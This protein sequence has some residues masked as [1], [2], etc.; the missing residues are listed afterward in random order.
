MP[1]SLH[2]RAIYYNQQGDQTLATFTL[3]DDFSDDEAAPLASPRASTLI[4]GDAANALTITDDYLSSAGGAA[5]N[6][7]HVYFPLQANVAGTALFARLGALRG[8]ISIG[9]YVGWIDTIA[10]SLGTSTARALY[11]FRFAEMR[12]TGTAENFTNRTLGITSVASY[13]NPYYADLMIVLRGTGAYWFWRR[14]ATW[15]L[16]HVNETLATANL[17]PRYSLRG[18]GVTTLDK[19]G[20]LDAATMPVE[21]QT[22]NG[23]ATVLSASAGATGDAP[24][25]NSIITW[26]FTAATGVTQELMFRRTDD[27]NALIVRASQTGSTIKLI[28]IDAGVETEYNS[29]AQTWTNGTVY[30]V[31]V[32]ADGLFILVSVNDSFKFSQQDA[33]LYY[34][35]TGIKAVT[36]A[37][38][39]KAYPIAPITST[40]VAPARAKAFWAWGDSITRGQ[41]DAVGTV[42]Q[43]GYVGRYEAASGYEEIYRSAFSGGTVSSIRTNKQLT[44]GMADMTGYPDFIISYMG[45]NNAGLAIGE[46]TWK[47]NWRYLM[48]AVHTR[49]PDAPVYIIKPWTNTSQDANYATLHGWIDD[50]L[51]EAEFSYCSVAAN[52]QTLFSASPAT[53]LDVDNI[54]PTAAGHQLIADTL[55]SNIP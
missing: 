53:Y 37:T 2:H 32:N 44:D 27:N 43:N 47:T 51:A 19:I 46:S 14:G 34:E 33:D 30:T 31:C 35:N 5:Y 45:T 50:L 8:D 48:R 23:L 17:Y 55:A 36:A 42:G 28:H 18:N 7:P 25:K 41:N 4:V 9:G 38:A 21:L 6:N 24:H 13:S 12:V 26:Q 11:Q 1:R 52:V 15:Q 54:H 22:Q 3:V 29:A 16:V 20:V 10:D 49:F 39:I 40:I